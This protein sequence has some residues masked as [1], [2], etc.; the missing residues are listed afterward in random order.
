MWL[1]GSALRLAGV[2][3]ERHPAGPYVDPE[4]LTARES[5]IGVAPLAAVI[6]LLTV[7][8]YRLLARLFDEW[9][10]LAA[11]LLIALDPFHIANSKVLHVD[12]LL[13]AW[14]ACAGLSLLVYAKER[15]WRWAA[16]SGALAGLALLTKAP[17][18]FLV[19]YAGLVLMSVVFV[20][21]ADDWRREV[22][23]GWLW[24][25]A[26]VGV[27]CAL[28]P[29][30]WVAP[31][32]TLAQVYR[33]AAFW[34]EQPHTYP[35]YYAGRMLVGDPGPMYYIHTW[36]YKVPAVV[37]VF[38]ALGVGYAALLRSWALH[39]R[40]SVGLVFAFV[41][42]FT[43]QMA[44][45]AKKMPRYLLPAWPMADVLAGVGLVTW[46][47]QMGR[48]AFRRTAHPRRAG[49]TVS[50]AL[51]AGGLLLQAVLVLP[52]H[53]YYDTYFN[54]LAGSARSGVATLS[55]QWQGEG[56][57][58]AARLM[59]TWPAAERLTVASHRAILFRQYFVGQTVDVAEPAD[60]VVLGIHNV[61]K[62]GE[63]GEEQVVDFYRRRQP[64]LS[65]AFDGMPYVGVYRAGT[66]PQHEA[67]YTF[68]A[69]IALTGYDI[70]AEHVHPGDT[71]RLQLYWQAEGPAPEDYVVFVHLLDG[72]GRLVAQQDNPPVRGAR[73]T[74][75][76]QV[77]EVVVDPYDIA[78][79][80]AAPLGRYTLAVG[81]YRW[82]ALTRLAVRGPAGNSL[83]DDQAL[84]TALQVEQ[85]PLPIATWV[86]RGLA[87][88]VVASALVGPVLARGTDERVRAA[89]A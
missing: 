89:E 69:G 46:A 70:A 19:P 43:L 86:A 74:S 85:E 10:A 37:A 15:R 3:P 29:A 28:F 18:L 16:L 73:P 17:A 81:M 56:L 44:L 61:L 84:L 23:A 2:L 51:A 54:A 64:E 48:V 30:M 31:L 63:Q 38:A 32:R 60:W 9:I 20:H 12:G 72:E 67:T 24:L 80:A 77:G 57:D 87:L 5:A 34:I 47:R 14:M 27:Y 58:L 4:T 41:F 11:A 45:G 6:A 25:V 71:V 35:I 8:A 88:L 26:L 52:R 79:P 59:N 1:A 22:V 82:P 76:W 68:E 42:F 55:T 50:A 78:I 49:V 83:T 40:I 66:T 36:A 65:I 53:P 21:R 39:K 75:G 13:A 33:G 62:G 7:L